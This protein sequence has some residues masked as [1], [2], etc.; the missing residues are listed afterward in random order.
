[1]RINS[2]TAYI[3]NKNTV[4]QLIEELLKSGYTLKDDIRFVT[5]NFGRM[6]DEGY[7]IPIFPRHPHVQ[8]GSSH[9]KLS[10]A[11][12]EIDV[13]K[14]EDRVDGVDEVVIYNPR[15]IL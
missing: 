9:S 10:L 8:Y 7:Y 12:I 15:I 4:K 13:I 6:I 2:T 11:E 5:K 1:M 14:N 3:V